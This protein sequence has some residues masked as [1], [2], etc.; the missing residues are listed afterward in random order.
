MID[1]GIKESF[2]KRIEKKR[3]KIKYLVQASLYLKDP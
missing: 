3:F 2:Q 1:A